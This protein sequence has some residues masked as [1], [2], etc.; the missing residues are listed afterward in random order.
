MADEE[1]MPPMLDRYRVLDLTGNRGALC[2]KALAELG[3]DVI[4][5]EKPGGDPSRTI[6]PFYQDI[7]GPERSLPWLAFNLNKRGITLNIETSKGQELFKRLIRTADFV[8]ESFTPGYLDNLDLGYS[9]LSEINPGII[10]TSITPF[11]QTGPYSGYNAP[12]LITMAMSGYLYL[13][14]DS[15][16][17]PVRFSSDQSYLQGSLQAAVG[18]LIAHYHRELSGEGQHV[19]VSVQESM[20]W[21]LCYAPLDWYLLKALGQTR[22]GGYWQRFGVT[23]RVIWPCKDGYVAYRLLMAQP[24]ANAMNEFVASLNAEGLG[25]DMK[26]IDWSN[27]RFDQVP[28]EDIDRWEDQIGT[29][30]LRHTK[31]ELHEEAVRQRNVLQPVNTMQDIIESPQLAARDFWVEVEH[32]ELNTAITYPGPYFKSTET[33]WHKGHRAPLIGEH[34]EE[35]YEKELGLSKEELS[36]LMNDNII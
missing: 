14:G 30:F 34:N 36:A 1:Q 35:I 27:L 7:P 11:G 32:P 4:K 20:V 5:V 28:Q 25:E 24:G 15:D 17:P 10:L 2:G 3:A 8:I 21:A 6:G 31:R 22:Q 12:D 29:Y 9:S 18:T 23:Y 16:R 26:G 13:C 33:A 19:D